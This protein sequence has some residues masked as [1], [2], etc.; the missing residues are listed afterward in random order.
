[1]GVRLGFLTEL[2]H[3]LAVTL[4]TCHLDLSEPQRAHPYSGDQD[5]P[6]LTGVQ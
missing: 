2:G 6:D 1:M 3:F 4:G 5:A